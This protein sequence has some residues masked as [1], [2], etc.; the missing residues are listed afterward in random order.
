M[1]YESDRGTMVLSRRTLALVEQLPTLNGQYVVRVSSA[2]GDVVFIT[3]RPRNPL[4]EFETWRSDQ[5]LLADA[6]QRYASE[7]VVLAGDFA[8]TLDHAPLR[9]VREL[10]FKDA[11]EAEGSGGCRPIPR[12]GR[13]RPS[14]P[15][16][17]CSW[18]AACRRPRSGRSRS[19]GPITSAWSPNWPCPDARE[20][21]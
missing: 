18:A 14:S 7:P 20:K 15:S 6:A 2:G 16:T 19:T 1:G 9:R 3:A 21:A 13:Y 17:T 10:G 12:T 8:A 11:A 5:R 4:H